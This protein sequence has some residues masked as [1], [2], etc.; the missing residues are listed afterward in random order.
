MAID[1]GWIDEVDEPFVKE[2]ENLNNEKQTYSE[3]EKTIFALNK[4]NEE[5]EMLKNSNGDPLEIE[6]KQN[7]INK[8]REIIQ[9]MKEK[10]DLSLEE[11][12]NVLNDNEKKQNL[13]FGL[14]PNATINQV[15]NLFSKVGARLETLKNNNENPTEIEKIQ[16]LLLE[17][18]EI[19]QIM[20]EKGP[21]TTIEEAVNEKKKLEKQEE[22]ATFGKPKVPTLKNPNAPSHYQSEAEP[23]DNGFF[24]TFIYTALTCSLLMGAYMH[25]LF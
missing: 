24:L 14:E 25:M 9:I 22:N 21:D 17:L 3:L 15:V 20:E 2:P 19:I 10:P 5:V 12:I 23:F 11:A 4:V 18:D 6:K 8:L 13:I 7:L 1:N 16:N